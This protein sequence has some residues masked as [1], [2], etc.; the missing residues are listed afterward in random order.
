MNATTSPSVCD[1][2]RLCDRKTKKYCRRKNDAFVPYSLVHA[3]AANGAVR[4]TASETG[5]RSSF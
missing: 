2:S 4:A 3:V 1:E 5:S